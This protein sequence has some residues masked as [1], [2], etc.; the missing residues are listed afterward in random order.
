MRAVDDPR[1]T[2]LLLLAMD[3][4]MVVLRNHVERTLDAGLDD[5]DVISRW[6]TA[7]YDL[8]ARA[9]LPQHDTSHDT[10]HDT[11]HD[12]SPTETS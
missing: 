5:P 1:M 4:G 7:E 11:P 12:T 2:T 8:F 3:L 10:S 9:L 6:V